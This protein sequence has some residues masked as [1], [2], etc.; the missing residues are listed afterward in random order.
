MCI[1]VTVFGSQIGLFKHKKEYLVRKYIGIEVFELK[2]DKLKTYLQTDLLFLYS[3]CMGIQHA[4]ID[5]LSYP[6]RISFF[7]VS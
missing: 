3:T 1:N 5:T 6:V 4:S 7:D 2:L